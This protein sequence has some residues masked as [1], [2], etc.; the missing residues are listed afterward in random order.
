MSIAAGMALALAMIAGQA[1]AAPSSSSEMAQIFAADQA[2]RKSAPNI[3][4]AVVRPRDAARRTATR[5]L[6]EEGA[7]N[8]AQDFKSAAFVFQHG[9]EAGDY[10]LAHSL[11]MVAVAKGDESALWI[12][13]A[14]LDRYLW[15][16]KQPQIYGTQFTRPRVEGSAWTQEPYDRALV[17]D[18]LRKALQVRTQAEQQK[19]LDAMQAEGAPR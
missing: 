5:R 13:S 10:L 19:Q 16:I 18:A 2:D 1:T 11:A 9:R 12:A 14:T 17:S 6:L 8:T 7:L 4:W 15:T 3:D